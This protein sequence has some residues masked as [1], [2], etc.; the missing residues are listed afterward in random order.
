[1][2]ND[3]F[4]NFENEVMLRIIKEDVKM[5]KMLHLQYITSNVLN[6]EFTGYGFYTHFK[7]DSTYRLQ[8]IKKT[9]LG[10]VHADIN[11]LKY[12]VGFVLY[13]NNG[14]IDMLECYTYDEKWP[15]DFKEYHLY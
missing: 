4:L 7:V 5:E 8:E 14:L 12:G 2:I 9:V 10:N 13:I 1:M 11:N 3:L 15:E 6:R